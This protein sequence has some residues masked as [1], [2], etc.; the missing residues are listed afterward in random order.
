M[1]TSINRILSYIRNGKYCGKDSHLTEEELDT[2]NKK[3]LRWLIR[4]NKHQTFEDMSLEKQLAILHKLYKSPKFLT[5]FFR[6]SI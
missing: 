4:V 2:Y 1:N 5:Q 6:L 3:T